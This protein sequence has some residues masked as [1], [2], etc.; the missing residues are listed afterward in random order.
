MIEITFLQAVKACLNNNVMFIS[1]IKGYLY[2]T[3]HYHNVF[4]NTEV[5]GYFYTA[6]DKVSC[7]MSLLK[8]TIDVFRFESSDIILSCDCKEKLL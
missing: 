1:K 4:G 2:E 8:L 5:C 7:I 6:I 3:R